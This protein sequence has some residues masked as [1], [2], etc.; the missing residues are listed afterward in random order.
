MLIP[1]SD[2]LTP[3]QE[4]ILDLFISND[5]LRENLY[6][7]GGTALS[8]CYLNHRYSDDLD[9]FSNEKLDSF[10][11]NTIVQKWT[12]KL[13]IAYTS[14]QVE[15][16][17]LYFLKYSND[18]ELKVDFAQYPYP[19]VEKLIDIQGLKVNS[20]KD[21][22]VNKCVTISQRSEVKDFVDLYYL[23]KE[24]SIYELHELANKKFNR[25]YDLMLLAAD[26]LKIEHFEYLPRMILPLTLAQ[27]REFFI[28]LAGSMGAKV[29]KD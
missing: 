23:L 19:N 6:F 21:L 9:F 3:Q 11:L 20:Q 29:T 8:A 26:L 7:T 27:I 10:Q 14:R 13:N 2:L 16:T 4:A 22:A 1:H 28:G 24:Y 5:F 15:D 17:Y 12:N 18:Y 25:D